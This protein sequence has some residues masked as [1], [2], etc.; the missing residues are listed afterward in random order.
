MTDQVIGIHDGRNT[1]TRYTSEAVVY[2]LHIP[3][4][5]IQIRGNIDALHQQMKL[6][7]AQPVGCRQAFTATP[8]HDAQA[9]TAGNV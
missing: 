4:D 8:V 3:A 7:P 5:V 1:G 2:A 6:L 9:Q